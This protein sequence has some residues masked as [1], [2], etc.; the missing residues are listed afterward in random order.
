MKISGR[1]RLKGEVK[2]VVLGDVMAKVVLQ[3]GDNR[4]TSVITREAAEEMG[5]KEGKEITALIKSTE[6]MLMEE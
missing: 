4:I 3:V 2:K 6:V 1:N 5:I